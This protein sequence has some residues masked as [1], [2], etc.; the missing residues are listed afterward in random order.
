MSMSRA[1]EDGPIHY[2]RQP[3][4]L[5]LLAKQIDRLEEAGYHI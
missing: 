1:E 4:D 2:M 5:H 3:H